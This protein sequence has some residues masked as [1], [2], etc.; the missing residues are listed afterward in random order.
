M[1]TP[2]DGSVEEGN[3][4]R[5]SALGLSTIVVSS[6]WCSTSHATNAELQSLFFAAC[7][8]PTDALAARC[9][10]TDG[11]AG[12][13]S[14][15]SE[16][17]LNPSQTLTPS[18]AAL[19]G[20]LGRAQDAEQRAGGGV[21]PDTGPRVEIGRFS[22]LVDFGHTWEDSD[23]TQDLD[24]ERGFDADINN[25]NLGIDYRLSDTSFVGL[26]L[27]YEDGELDFDRE[28][29]G[30]N[31]TPAK[32]AG[33]IDSESFGVS[34]FASFGLGS[35]AYLDLS[36]GYLAGE[37][38]YER[39]S[40]FQ[41]SNRVVPQTNS[42][43]SG[44]ADT[45][46]RWAS[47]NVGWQHSRDAWSFGVYAGVTYTDS[48]IDGFAERDLTG[49][50]LGMR[51]SGVDQQSLV[52]TLG[53]RAQRAIST[54]SGVLL[55]HLR[56]EYAREFEDDPVDL[57]TAYVLDSAG[58]SLELSGDDIDE[59]FVVAGIGLSAIFPNG[60][61]PFIDFSYW[62]GYKDLDRMRIQAGLRKEL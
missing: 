21:A 15:D 18:Q 49:T 62:A 51:F 41:E 1:T 59:D 25:L 47:A 17:S 16:S 24:R 38:D 11:G 45:E 8:N 27:S 55:P 31:F 60:W 52:G 44:S 54:G 6:M 56:L 32:T 58:A 4:M 35:S 10:E 46:E 26:L 22:V 3:A 40:V 19:R 14:G 48:D 36:I 7:A 2:T 50:G 23:K 43:T 29:E 57:R 13:L 37:N 5:R 61:V 30:R 28:A 53:V 34:A 20:A 33:S 42:V 39:R 9:A 12:D